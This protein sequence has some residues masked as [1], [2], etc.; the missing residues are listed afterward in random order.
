MKKNN[1]FKKTH[2]RKR[3]V[4]F[5]FSEEIENMIANAPKKIRRSVK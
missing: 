3:K 2:E 4:T 1:T 5:F